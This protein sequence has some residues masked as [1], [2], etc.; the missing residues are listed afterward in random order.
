MMERNDTSLSLYCI[1]RVN[2]MLYTS[3]YLNIYVYT[4]MYTFYIYN[5]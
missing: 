4:C 3:T 1:R 5:R 2:T